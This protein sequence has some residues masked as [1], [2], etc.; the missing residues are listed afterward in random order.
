MEKSSENKSTKKTLIIIGAVVAG[1][2]LIFAARAI[3]VNAV[4]DH[5][6]DKATKEYNKAYDKAKRDMDKTMRQYGF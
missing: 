2:I 5:A 3:Y 6:Y 4:M 1:I